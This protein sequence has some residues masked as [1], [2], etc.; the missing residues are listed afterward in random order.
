M[1]FDLYAKGGI[2]NLSSG[3]PGVTVTSTSTSQ[4]YIATSSS[5]PSMTLTLTS[6]SN[7]SIAGSSSSSYSST[8]STASGSLT[9][10]TTSSSSSPSTSIS[11]SSQPITLSS[12]TSKVITSSSTSSTPPPYV[13]PSP[14]TGNRI[15]IN[16]SLNWVN[17]APDGTSRP[18]I[19]INGQWPC[20]PIVVNHGDD[21]VLSVYNGLGNESTA[22][23]FHGLQ[24]RNTTYADGPSWVTQCP[25][26][27]GETIVYEF[28]A[29]QIGT[30]WYHAHHAGQ[31][32]DGLRGPF[33]VKDPSPPYG[34]VDQDIT[35][36]LTDFYHKQAPSL[37]NYYQSSANYYDNGGDEPLPDAAL[38]NEA[39]N[40]KFTIIPGQT[41]LFRVI[42]MGAMAAQYLQFD[43]H[44]MT[45][46]E[47]DGQYVQ[48]YTVQQLFVA[49]AQRYTVLVNSKPNASTNY[50]II[51]SMDTSMFSDSGSP[52][53]PSVS[54]SIYWPLC[55]CAN[56]IKVSGWLVYDATNTLP[57]PFTLAPQPWNELAMVPLDQLALFD[58]PSST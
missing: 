8:S 17:S 47:I 2:S 37:I 4:S 39:Q 7:T 22:I 25:I 46:V 44:N 57:A 41:N 11:F 36:T 38:I 34:K 14:P 15:N 54:I 24:Q 9:H 51:A 3:W 28:Q 12:S 58:P 18:V 52:A 31:Y 53:N 40:V 55:H 21:L 45:V 48:P 50:A 19:G 30:Y 43:G 10:S 32:I 1:Q 5:T 35:L 13:T 26:P 49:V 27:P 23:H 16:W 42:N 33:I 56:N 29:R 6:T 20:P